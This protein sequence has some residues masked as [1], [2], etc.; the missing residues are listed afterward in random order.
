MRWS[1]FRNIKLFTHEQS[2]HESSERYAYLEEMDWTAILI[3]QSHLNY[4]SLIGYCWPLMKPM[5]KL[6]GTHLPWSA[7]DLVGNHQNLSGEIWLHW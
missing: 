6:V 7:E 1:G 4:F 2:Q 3:L 5:E